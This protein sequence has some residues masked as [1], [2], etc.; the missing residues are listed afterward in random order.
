MHQ[1]WSLRRLRRLAAA[2]VIV[3]AACYVALPLLASTRLVRDSIALELA[4]WSGYRVS[5]GAAP[6]IS[7][8]P[9]FRAT[10]SNVTLSDWS[11]TDG[12]PVITVEELE[13]DLSPLAALR[14]GVEFSAARFVR[15][16]LYLDATETG[17]A[18]PPLPLSSRIARSVMTARAALALNPNQPN[19]TELPADA[20]GSVEIVDGT[21]ATG[22]PAD[23]RDIAADISGTIDLPALNLPGRIVGTGRVNAAPVSVDIHAEQPLLLL[24]GGLSRLSAR[25]ESKL[26]SVTFDGAFQVDEKIEGKASFSTSS[27]RDG[28]AWI[29]QNLGRGMT[30][31]PVSLSAA[32][33]GSPRQLKLDRV[34]MRIGASEAV[35]VLDFALAK[36]V[37]SLSG[38]LAFQTLDLDDALAVF[39]P[40]E[41]AAGEPTPFK[42]SNVDL[43]VSATQ[44]TVGSVAL[45]D[46][47]AS[48]NIHDGRSAFDISDATAF[49]GSL[50]AALRINDRAEP[51]MDLSVR[52][53]DI[54]GAMLG[55]ARG[56]PRLV[57]AAQGSFT[58][59]LKGPATRL[60]A[61]ADTADGSIAATFGAGHFEALDLDSFLG[62]V[63]RGGFFSLDNV[64]KRTLEIERADFKAAVKGGVAT[65]DIAD[66]EFPDRRLAVSGVAPIN[67]QGLALTGALLPKA[68]ADAKP[69]ARFFIGGS[70]SEPFISST[71][72]GNPPE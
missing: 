70:W 54:D 22:A 1:I 13:L 29:D 56:L 57:P 37:P 35:G 21:V 53:F 20:F 3:L 11:R 44:A 39:D 2:A 58:V 62:L 43:R 24:A 67:G 28:L 50:Q 59:T 55:Q 72:P 60:S 46:V 45:A 9:G 33:S 4:E 41:K 18:L 63:D 38:T 16:V 25:V 48:V 30:D 68:P 26:L 27:A 19:F 40:Y 71:V 12:R 49:G 61:M 31:T 52:G 66:V 65:I 17:V 10:L 64:A 7:V 15:P 5:L 34:D 36:A 14:G 23:Q 47:A 8:W 69:E 6:E 32:L 42:W 51:G